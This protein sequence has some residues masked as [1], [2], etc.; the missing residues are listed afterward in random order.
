MRLLTLEFSGIMSL[1]QAEATLKGI[2]P[3]DLVNLVLFFLQPEVEAWDPMILAG[4]Q[5]VEEFDESGNYGSLPM[6]PTELPL[7]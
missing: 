4:W 1:V 2:L 7:F 6:C 3:R 5:H